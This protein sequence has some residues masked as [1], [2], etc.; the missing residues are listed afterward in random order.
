MLALCVTLSAN[1][2]LVI[3]DEP[4]SSLDPTVRAEVA[5]L[6]REAQAA[7]RTVIFSSHVLSEVEEVCD[8]VTILR[9]GHVVHQQTLA[10]LTRQ[11]RIRALLTAPIGSPPENVAQH[12]GHFSAEGGQLQ[13]VAT[14]ELAPMLGWLSTLP[15]REVQIEPLGLRTVYDRFHRETSDG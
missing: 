10:E 11:H 4:T 7:G 13:I 8:R 6:V 3:L 2:P 1:V 14:G 9:Q 15:I 12:L 5:M